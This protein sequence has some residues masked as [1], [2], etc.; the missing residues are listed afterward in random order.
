MQT[1]AVARPRPTRPSGHTVRS[2]AVITTLLVL[3]GGLAGCDAAPLEPAG[4][5]FSIA[6][7]DLAKA[8]TSG[9]VSAIDPGEATLAL[10]SSLRLVALDAQGNVLQANWSTSA[11]GVASVVDGVVTAVGTGS[12]RITARTRNQSASATV[13]VVAPSA[14]V[15]VPEPTVVCA[16]LPHTRLVR[17][18]TASELAGALRHAQPGDLIHLADGTYTGY[19]KITVS[20]TAA[21]PAAL[22][23]SRGAILQTGTLTGGHALWLDGASHWVLAGFTATNSL[24]GLSISSGSHNVVHGVAVRNTCQHGIRIGINSSHNTVRNSEISLTGRVVREYGEGI[25]VGSYHEHWCAR[26]A[27]EPDRS[28]HNR[29]LDNVIGPDVTAEHVQTM[30]GTTGGLIRGNRF[31]GTGLYVPENQWVDSWVAVM[32]NGWVVEDNHGTTTPRNGFEVWVSLPGWGNDN[33]FR[34]NTADVQADGFGFHVNQNAT[35]NVVG[36]DNVVLQAKSGFA[37]VSCQ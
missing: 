16:D 4:S 32:G 23:G 21:Q 6:A 9:T 28:D 34:R 29:V 11:S 27:C 19:W 15:P 24:G 37:N 36:C 7:P 18:A 3:A 30:E 8:G 12:A 14:S 13:T 10:G 35:G 25:Y 26:T 31:D 1:H 2:T 17:V 33:V 5:P 20:G 22:C